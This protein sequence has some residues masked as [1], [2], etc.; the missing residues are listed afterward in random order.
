VDWEQ[1]R[2]FKNTAGSAGYHLTEDALARLEPIM[3]ELKG[4]GAGTALATS[5]GRLNGIVKLPNQI[6]HLLTEHGV[7]DASKVEWN[8]QGGIK[9]LRGSPM[10]V[11]N[12]K[13]FQ[14]N[15]ELFYEKVMRPIYEKMK[16]SANEITIENAAIFGRTGG[17]LFNAIENQLTVVH[18]S[19]EAINAMK[20]LNASV[21]EARKS[22]SGQEQEFGA[23]WADF[24]TQFGTSMLPFFSGLLK[25]GASVLRVINSF[26]DEGAHPKAKTAGEAFSDLFTL[27]LRL[28][29]VFGAPDDGGGRGSINPSNVNPVA[30]PRHASMG[31]NGDVY[32]DGKKVGQVLSGYLS[33]E[34]SRPFANV[35]GFDPGMN[36]APFNVPN[37]K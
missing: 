34:A 33:A 35:G 1:L 10:S 5:M 25:G 13:L 30:T 6:A 21:D 26:S 11:E 29:M 7:W 17:K 16:L 12:A 32:L 8:A 2:Q 9:R 31:K 27:P 28:G 15:P 14:E 19:I 3:G 18:K 22:L 24:K 23:A 20:G 4:G 36:L 37:L